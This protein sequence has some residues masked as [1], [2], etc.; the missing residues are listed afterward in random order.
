MSI[1]SPRAPQ[2]LLLLGLFG[3]FMPNAQAQ[4]LKCSVSVDIS[5]LQGPSYTHLRDLQAPLSEYLSDFSWTEDVFE[6]V[7]QIDCRF[8]IHL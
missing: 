3:I 7:E 6:E 8:Q 4:E 1:N 5:Q 2:L